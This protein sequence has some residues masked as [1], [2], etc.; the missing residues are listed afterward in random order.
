MEVLLLN[1]GFQPMGRVPWQ[2]AM[3]LVVAGRAEVLGTYTDRAIRT[4][5]AAF[6]MPS[7]VRYVRGRIHYSSKRVRL[8]K[9]TLHARDEGLCQYCS[10]SLQLSEA[11]LDHV[12]PRSR[13][14]KAQWTNVALAC[15]PCNAKKGN[16]TP[17]EAR[18]TLR[19]SPSKP[20]PGSL[21]LMGLRWRTDM[22]KAW[23][24]YLP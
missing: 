16:R 8:T 23:R 20:K 24:D 13:G 3:T 22:P 2:R 10:K 17:A 12:Q 15:R 5:S 6:K 11:T 19:R 21:D 4:V 9:R 7:V 14:G 1:M 18:M